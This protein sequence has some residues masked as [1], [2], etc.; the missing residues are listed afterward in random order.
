M[1]DLVFLTDIS[2]RLNELN[3]KLQ[4]QSKTIFEL[5]SDVK[6]FEVKLQ[7]FKTQ[8]LKQNFLHFKTCQ[9]I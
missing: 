3:L 2:A 9:D 8:I 4:K 5:I 6:S 7:L 1:Y